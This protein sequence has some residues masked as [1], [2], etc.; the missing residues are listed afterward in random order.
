MGEVKVPPLKIQGIKTKAIPY[1]KEVAGKAGY[2]EKWIEPFMGSGVA[3]FNLAG[4]DALFSDKNPHI[5]KF[6]Q[7]IQSGLVTPDAVREYL[8]REGALLEEH[9]D[10][11]YYMVRDRFNECGEPLDFLFL[12]RACFN[13]MVRFNKNHQFNVPY[14]HKPKRFSKAYVTKIVNQVAYVMQRIKDSHWEFVCADF[15]ELI[16]LA[17][18]DDLIYCDPPYIGRNADY[19]SGW[20]EEEEE[21]LCSLLQSTKAKFILS[22]WG[23]NQ[24]RENEYIEKLWGW[25][26]QAGFEHFYHVGGKEENR[27]PMKE[28]LLTN[29]M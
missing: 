7:A 20:G 6:Y 21:R 19:Y 2:R 23:G 11:H 14:C 18:E 28:L 8:E 25:C 1:I 4:H 9:D 27:N 3:G 16:K 13:G 29:F 26:S 5:I 17:G 10:R 22:T 15:S 12:N 24:Y